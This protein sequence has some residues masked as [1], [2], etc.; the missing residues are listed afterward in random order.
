MIN[1]LHV[2]FVMVEYFPT[3]F[4]FLCSC[5]NTCELSLIIICVAMST[6]HSS[7]TPQ[8]NI[9]INIGP[10]FYSDETLTNGHVAQWLWSSVNDT[11]VESDNLH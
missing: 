1:L 11:I 3:L 5:I 2:R 10:F 4:Q 9:L 6:S 7:W 8:Q